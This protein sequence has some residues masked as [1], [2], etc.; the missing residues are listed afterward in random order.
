M[1]DHPAFTEVFAAL[2]ACPLVHHLFI[3]RIPSLDVQTDRENALRI[4]NL[5]H[6]SILDKENFG[7][8]ATGEQ[9]HRAEVGIL[10][11]SEDLPEFPL[12]GVDALITD[13]SDIALGIYVADCAAVYLVD[14]TGGAIG[15]IH[16]GK[17]GTEAGIVAR[18]VRTMTDSFGTKPSNL[19]LQISPCIRTPNYEV[20]FPAEIKMQAWGAGIGTVEDCSRCTASDLEHYYSYR[21]E[22]SRTGRMLAVLAKHPPE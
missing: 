14:K 17:K 16:A 19:I 18:T 9:V 1:S 2:S 12:R 6:R 13:R 11:Q 21:K 8:L 22:K 15:L 4:L 20:D 7:P 10:R 3:G 5:P